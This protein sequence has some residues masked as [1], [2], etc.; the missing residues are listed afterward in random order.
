MLQYVRSIPEVQ[1]QVTSPGKREG[2]PSRQGLGKTS[3]L[4]IGRAT[5]GRSTELG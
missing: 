3:N 4:N 5:P 1:P 2:L